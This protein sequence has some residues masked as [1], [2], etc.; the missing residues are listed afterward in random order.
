MTAPYDIKLSSCHDSTEITVDLTPEQLAFLAEIAE[1][2]TVTSQSRC[3]PDMHIEPH[4]PDVVELCPVCG[5]AG[6]CRYDAEGR[7]LIHTDTELP[8]DPQ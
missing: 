1:K 3:E 4:V 7:A 2:I 8:E 6:A 5:A